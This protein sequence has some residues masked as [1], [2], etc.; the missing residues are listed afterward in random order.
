MRM[1]TYSVVVQEAN[2]V[3]QNLDAAAV[4]GVVGDG[5]R[6]AALVAHQSQ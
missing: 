3:A 1:L 6:V 5:E 4:V 2:V